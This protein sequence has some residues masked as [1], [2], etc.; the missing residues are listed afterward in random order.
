MLFKHYRNYRIPKK[1]ADRYWKIA[2]A[3]TS[4]KVVAFS[5]HA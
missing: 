1:D 2:P 4:K 3:A 5:G